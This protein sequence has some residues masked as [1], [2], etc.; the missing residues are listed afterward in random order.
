MLDTIELCKNFQKKNEGQKLGTNK[1]RNIKNIT[2]KKSS[3]LYAQCVAVQY[4]YKRYECERIFM[5]VRIV[6]T[7][8]RAVWAHLMA[9]FALDE[10]TKIYVSSMMNSGKTVCAP[11]HKSICFLYENVCVNES[12]FL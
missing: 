10:E 7:H 2:I 9:L 8:T 1:E 5:L 4:I 3:V 12:F 11:K 6:Y